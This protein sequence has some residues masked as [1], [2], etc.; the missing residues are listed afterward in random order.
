M[1]LCTV[2]SQA[3]A[4][5]K[6]EAAAEHIRLGEEMG[7]LAKRGHW[8]GVDRSYRTIE[9]LQGKGVRLSFGDHYLGAQAARELGNVTL[10]YRRLL[11]AQGLK[12]DPDVNNWLKDILA[13][14]GEVDLIIPRKY[15][16]EANLAVAMMPLQPDQRST[17]G[18]AQG[19]IGEGRSYSGL[20]PG[21]DY[22][23]GSHTFKV[24][25]GGDTIVLQVSKS[26][27]S[28]VSKRKSGETAPFRFS[29]GGPR[30]DLGLAWTQ[31]TDGG[32]NAGPGGF[33][34]LGGRFAAGYEA[35]L[36]DT[37]GVLVEGGYMGLSGSPADASG[38]LGDVDAFD[39]RDDQM[40]LGFMWLAGVAD[41][42]PV[43]MAVGPMYGFG[44]ASVTGVSQSCIDEPTGAG[45]AEFGDAKNQTLRYSR[46]DGSIKAG[47]GALGLGYDILDLG[48]FQ[49]AVSLNIGAL[50]DTTRWYPFGSLGITVG[51]KGQERD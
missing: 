22:T 13:Q 23:F 1:V 14:Y 32:S 25:P 31:G 45:C 30:V 36:G 5:S 6:S 3:H 15:K 42:G 17:I 40:N 12:S 9:T 19:R 21:G 8:R 16:G 50:S 51:P 18:M 28:Q 39:L 27:G 38:T 24:N 26:G 43:W 34:G 47:G 44:G 46:M 41:I 35:G 2:P 4:I 7:R 20:L 11:E 29:Y 33:G 37:F 10:V 48:A 49:G